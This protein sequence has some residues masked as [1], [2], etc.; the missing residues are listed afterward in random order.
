MGE[1]DAVQVGGEATVV[2]GESGLGRVEDTKSITE[3][4][5][6]KKICKKRNV[7]TGKTIVFCISRIS[8][9]VEINDWRKV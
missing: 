1:I 5:I 8:Y 6:I 3:M 9:T 7:T 4:V 2:L